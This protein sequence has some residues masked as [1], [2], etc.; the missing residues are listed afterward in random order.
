[1]YPLVNTNRVYIPN[2]DDLYIIWAYFCS[3][4]TC[5]DK[6]HYRHVARSSNVG[7][8]VYTYFIR[9]DNLNR[10]D[11]FENMSY[12]MYVC[13][14]VRLMYTVTFEET[15]FAYHNILSFFTRAL[16]F[17][18]TFDFVERGSRIGRRARERINVSRPSVIKTRVL[19]RK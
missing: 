16:F 1:M 6:C 10:Y 19:L 14:V 18:I 4:C 5:T 12:K 8:V 13:G 3:Y 7:F 2:P 9:R 17:S 15:E 11:H